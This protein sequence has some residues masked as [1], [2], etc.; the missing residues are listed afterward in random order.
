LKNPSELSVPLESGVATT[1]LV[2]AADRPTAALILAHG[3]GAGQLH[4]FMVRFG[5]ALSARNID[6]VTFNF[7]YTAQRRR[8]PDRG[9]VLEACYRSVVQAVADR[10]ESARHHLFIGGKSMGGRIATQIAAGAA[11]P[12]RGLVLLGYPLHPPGRPEQ[13]RDRHLPA[14][15]RPMLF[16]QGSRDTFGTP[17]ELTPVL[18]G[19]IPPP[20]LHIVEGGDH[21][22]ALPK[23]DS[24]RQA[25]VFDDVQQAIVEW[26]SGLSGISIP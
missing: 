23:K 3:A 24:A 6:I 10:V 19:L 11:L 4:P 5:H 15:A 7:L 9:P 18:S 12:I 25:A 22:F 1:A 13:R 21:S 16:V 17:A 8:L 14:V 2:Y 26:I 20:A